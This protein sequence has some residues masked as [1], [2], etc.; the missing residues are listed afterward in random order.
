MRVTSKIKR[1]A[2][3]VILL[4]FFVFSTNALADDLM[5]NT[6]RNALY[7]G[8]VGALVGSAVLVLSKHPNDHL[9]YI[10]TGAGVGVLVG[11]AYGIASSGVITTASAAEIEKG[12]VTMHVPTV[13]TEKVYDDV[14]NVVEEIE[15]VQLVRLKF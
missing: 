1:I 14:A 12:K 8:I 7:G 2:S 10:P 15:T 4:V 13:K 6:M 9:S 11:A 3:L 5:Q